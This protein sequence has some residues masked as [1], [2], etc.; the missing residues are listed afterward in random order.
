[1]IVAKLLATIVGYSFGGCGGIFAPSLF[2]GGMSG[3]FLGGLAGIWIPLTPADHIVLAVV[4]MSACLGAI[5]QAPL[6][7]ILIVFEMTHQFSLVPGLLLGAIISQAMARLVSNLNFYDSLLI[8]DGHELHKI[9]PPHDLKGWQHLPLSAVATPKPVFLEDSSIKSMQELLDQ[10]PYNFFP[11]MEKDILT[12]IMSRQDIIDCIKTGIKPIQKQAVICSPE[13]TI[14]DASKAF[15][16]HSVPMVLVGDPGS[17]K[18][19]GLLTL[20]DLI[21]A[22]SSWNS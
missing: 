5:V 17:G 2:I 8:Q 1:M 15:I 9:K 20:H 16:N 4:G 21:R 6:T 14:H 11:V 18:V 22:Q 13:Q 19:T 12:G 3:Y 7:S 10:F